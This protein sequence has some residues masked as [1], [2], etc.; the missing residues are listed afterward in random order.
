[1]LI[2]PP[3]TDYVCYA[4]PITKIV[5]ILIIVGYVYIFFTSLKVLPYV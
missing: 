5:I 4:S 3:A 2:G 1:M